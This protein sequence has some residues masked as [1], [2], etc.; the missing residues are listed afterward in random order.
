MVKSFIAYKFTVL[1]CALVF[2]YIGFDFM[3]GGYKITGGYLTDMENTVKNMTYLYIFAEV[4]F[5]F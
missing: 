5:F 1:F 3:R 4:E 2:F